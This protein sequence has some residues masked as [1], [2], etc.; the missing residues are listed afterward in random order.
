[1]NVRVVSATHRDLGEE[2][3]AG[4]FRQDLY[5][6]LNVIQIRLPALRERLDDLASICEAVLQRIADDAGVAPVP[7]MAADALRCLSVYPFPGNVRELE[8][9]LQRALALSGG[10]VIERADLGLDDI[11]PAEPEAQPAAAQ[12]ATPAALPPV[13][14]AALPADLQAYLDG[15]ERDMLLRALERYRYNRTA[16]GAS[17]GLSLRQMRYRMARLGVTTG[18]AFGDRGDPS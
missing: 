11:G 12:P 7:T 17:M 6:R 3:H 10:E 5:Y 9:L 16:A 8:N 14:A 15:V 18:E 4:R 2:V 1:V 13:A